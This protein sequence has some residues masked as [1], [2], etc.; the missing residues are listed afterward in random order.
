MLKTWPF[1]ETLPPYLPGVKLL[2]PA[3][4]PVHCGP[5]MSYTEKKRR[6]PP[7][8]VPRTKTQEWQYPRRVGYHRHSPNAFSMPLRNRF[9]GL[10]ISEPARKLAQTPRGVPFLPPRPARNR[11]QPQTPRNTAREVQPRQVRTQPHGNSYFLQGKIAGKAATFL[12]DSGCTTSLISRQL[13]DTLSAKVSSELEPYD[14]EYGTLADGSCIPFYGIIELTG[15]VRN[16]AI[17]ETFIVS[18]LK[19]NAILE[20]PFLK[21]HRC[22]ID[23]NKSAM[24][25][26]DRELACVDRFGGPLVGG[27]QV[28]RSCTIPGRSRPTIHSRGNSS[29]ISGLGVV[30]VA[31][32]RIQLASSLNRLTARGEILVQCV[33]PFT[34]SV[35]LLAG[36]MLG[37]FHSVQEEDVGPSL[38]DTTEDLRQR[39]SRGRGTVS[40]HV[41]ELYEAACDGCT[42]NGERQAMAKLLCEYND[43]F[44]SGDHAVGL[45]RA[46]RHERPLAAGTVPIRQPT[47]RLGPKKEKEVS[48]QVRDLLDCGLIEPAHSA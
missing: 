23:F 32:D 11:R 36:S 28:V 2:R 16:Q 6:R 29:Q 27:V 13:F 1:S 17:Q 38:G 48:R 24:L 35:K 10:P 42:S 9:D 18:Q 40:P 12:L 44:S 19:E 4:V 41:K 31:H 37:R 22:C 3:D 45:T 30:E 20:M 39:L 47:R 34:E 15:R 5:M 26:G 8:R 14:G 43:V 33:N 46:V 25:M 7:R 21:R